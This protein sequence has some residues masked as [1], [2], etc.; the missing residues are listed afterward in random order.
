MICFMVWGK[1]LML[2]FKV[3]IQG[4]YCCILFEYNVKRYCLIIT[5]KTM[6]WGYNLSIRFVDMI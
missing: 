4:Y 1:I 2:I 3:Y 5:I 6:A